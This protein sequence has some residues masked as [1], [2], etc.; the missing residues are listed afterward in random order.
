MCLFFSEFP[1]IAFLCCRS[2]A[3][4]LGNAVKSLIFYLWDV[5]SSSTPSGTDVLTLLSIC[6]ACAIVTGGLLYHWLCNT[7]KYSFKASVQISCCYSL[8]LLLMSFLCHPLRCMLTMMLPIVSSNQGRKLLISASIL[9]LMLNV[10]PNI[11]VN[12]GAVARILKCTAEG[13][14]K[15]LLNS[16]ELFN[17]AKQDLVDE[18][19]KVEWEDLN[20][21]NNLKT[22]NNFTHVDVSLV[23]SKFAKV[24]GEIEEKFSGARDLIGEY[25]LLSNRILAAIF[26]ALLILESARYLKSYLTSVQFDNGY[27]SKELLQNEPCETKRSIRDKTKLGSCLMTNQECTS[28]FLS[29]IVVT[30]YF[31]AIALIVVLDYVVYYIVQLVMPWVVDFPPTAASISLNYKV[32]LFVPVLCLIPSSCVTQTLTNFHRDYRWDFN[33]EP[34]NCAVTTSAPNGG[35]TFLLGCLWL[36]SYFMVFLEVYAKRLCRKICASFYREQEERRMTYL[37]R[38]LQKKMVEKGDDNKGNNQ[39]LH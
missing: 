25:K 11:A 28:S 38:K 3:R 32:E 24:V 30:L 37:R 27:I 35:V 16:S 31:T 33:P 29:L 4:C 17:K 15:T 22:L 2:T 9:I 26:V 5:Y 20:I 10:I 23:K 6:S 7:L 13:F 8:A 18:T 36:M 12:I 14:A 1:N 39:P 21:V 34:S 19:I